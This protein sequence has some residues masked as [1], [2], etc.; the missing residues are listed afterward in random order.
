QRLGSF[1]NR[2]ALGQVLGP[3]W[4]DGCVVGHCG[5]HVVDQAPILPA[6][7]V[8]SSDRSHRQAIS[9]RLWLLGSSSLT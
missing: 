8:S 4:A 6:G 2:L 1:E 9:Y 7:A 5:L 3:A